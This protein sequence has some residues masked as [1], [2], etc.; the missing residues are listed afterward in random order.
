MNLRNK[1]HFPIHIDTS[2][3]LKCLGGKHV[4]KKNTCPEIFYAPKTTSTTPRVVCMQWA[5]LV[6]L[7]YPGDSRDRH[8]RYVL[9]KSKDGRV[10]L[11]T[12]CLLWGYMSTWTGQCTYTPTILF[13]IPRKVSLTCFLEVYVMNLNVKGYVLGATLTR[14]LTGLNLFYITNVNGI[15]PNTL[16]FIPSRITM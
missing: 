8:L 15:K 14:Y 5:H 6:H 16:H 2:V 12:L 4:K 11:R 10:K 7:C 1:P 3:R 13:G 9:Q